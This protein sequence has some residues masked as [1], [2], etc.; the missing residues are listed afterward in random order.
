M[1]KQGAKR[2][3]SSQR[4]NMT[5]KL[6][7]IRGIIRSASKRQASLVVN[8]HSWLRADLQSAEPERRVD[9]EIGLVRDK[10]LGTPP[11]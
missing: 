9:L 2:V 7:D 1:S 8:V 6:S 11:H 3:M 10:L 5:T 4:L